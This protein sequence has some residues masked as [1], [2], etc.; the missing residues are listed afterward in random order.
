MI[1]ACWGVFIWHEF[2]SPN[3]RTRR[4]LFWMFFNFLA[5]LAAIA[6]A[7]LVSW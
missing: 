3:A 7:P 2:R 6:F 1:S 4:L 5:G